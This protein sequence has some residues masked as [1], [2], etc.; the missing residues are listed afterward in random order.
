[1]FESALVPLDLHEP[2]RRVAAVIAFLRDL[3]VRDV[4][5][6]SVVGSS[7]A[8]RRAAHR[9]EEYV[10]AFRNTGTDGTTTNTTD[11]TTNVRTGSPA[12]EIVRGAENR[13]CGLIAIPW[14]RKSR[15]QRS[16]V[17]SVTR[18]VA[19]LSDTPVLVFR[20]RRSDGDDGLSLVYATD[21]GPVDEA[22]LPIIEEATT[23]IRSLTLIHAGERAPDPTTETRRAEE[24][25]NRLS[26][27]KE[28]V[29]ARRGGARPYPIDTAALIGR[30]RK[31]I[32]RFLTWRRPDLA[33]VG[34]GGR[35]HGINGIL[36]SVAEEVA[37]RA[38]TS[39]LIVPSGDAS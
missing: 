35:R 9:L 11:V 31:S 28:R 16:L 4:E 29:E 34:K 1:M 32:R 20:D 24:V 19:R 27:V 36:G 37:Y 33:I 13:E 17:G 10:A 18:D 8:G 7:H 5:L 6:L 3:G 14:K 22:V 30:P 38:T 15:L 2:Q 21:L 26:A 39:V 23:P 25:E 12:Q